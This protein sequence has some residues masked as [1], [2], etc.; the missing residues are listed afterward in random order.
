MKVLIDTHIAI[1]TLEDNPKLSE[2]ARKIL[3]DKANEIYFSVASAWE[4][5]H[6][7]WQSS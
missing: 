5:G 2:K 6:K 7:A 1:W 4:V 3:M